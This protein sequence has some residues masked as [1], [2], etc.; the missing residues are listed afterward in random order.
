MIALGEQRQ[1][2]ESER[3]RRHDEQEPLLDVAQRKER[4]HGDAQET[5]ARF[6]PDGDEE[7]RECER[8]REAGHQPVRAEHRP[9]AGEPP[10]HW[11]QRDRHRCKRRAFVDAAIVVDQEL[12]AFVTAAEDRLHAGADDDGADRQYQ[13]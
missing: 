6:G 11:H 3:R 10:D 4:E 5:G 2:R 8:Q 7:T 12:E 1:G 9:E 13:H